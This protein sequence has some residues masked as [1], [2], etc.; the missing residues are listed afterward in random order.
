MHSPDYTQTRAAA[1]LSLYSVPLRRVRFFFHV[2]EVSNGACSL[3][4]LCYYSADILQS[5]STWCITL[6]IFEYA[7]SVTVELGLRDPLSR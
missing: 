1:M 5:L 3:D 7:E 4:E 6:G 2:G